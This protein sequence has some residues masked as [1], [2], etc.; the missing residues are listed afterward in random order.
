[1]AVRALR[2]RSGP[3]KGDNSETLCSKNVRGPGW[4]RVPWALCG[5]GAVPWEWNVGS[6]APCRRRRPCSVLA[7]GRS[8]WRAPASGASALP[9]AGLAVTGRSLGEGRWLSDVLH[10]REAALAVRRC[11]QAWWRWVR[12]VFWARRRECSLSLR[13]I[14]PRVETDPLSRVDIRSPC[15]A[16]GRPSPRHRDLPGRGCGAG[17]AGTENQP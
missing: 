12:R 3:A 6:S 8:F 2:G 10:S 4:S 5:G 17:P 1:M 15:G 14:R 13:K 7:L 9:S 16:A 11:L